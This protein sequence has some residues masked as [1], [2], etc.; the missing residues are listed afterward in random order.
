MQG[1]EA[2]ADAGAGGRGSE[3]RGRGRGRR[4]GAPR[5]MVHGGGGMR[6]GGWGLGA[7]RTLRCSEMPMPMPA[8]PMLDAPISD[9]RWGI[10]GAERFERFA[11]HSEELLKIKGRWG[12]RWA[13]PNSPGCSLGPSPFASAIK[14]HQKST[15]NSAGSPVGSLAPPPPGH[16][17]AGRWAV[18]P[19]C[20]GTSLAPLYSPRGR[21]LPFALRF[22]VWG[23]SPPPAPR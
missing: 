21:R 5:G 22:G 4:R 9:L 19:G 14:C 10:L 15:C 11:V 3:Q 2:E 18:R 13:L 6:A 16:P 8:M 1:L 17:A 7:L 23:Q 20:A 12:I